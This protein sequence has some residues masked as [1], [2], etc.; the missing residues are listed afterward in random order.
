MTLETLVE[1]KKTIALPCAQWGDT[2]KG[3]FVDFFAEEWADIVIRGTGGAN[4]GHT[5]RFGDKEIV[6][7]LIPSGI[8]HDRT[9]TNIIGNGV[10]LDPWETLHEIQRLH[11]AGYSTD[12]LMISH[13][14]KL[15][16]PQHILLDRLEEAVAGKEKLGTT[17]RGIGKAYED[18]PAR[19]ALTVNDLLNPDILHKKL[20]RNLERRARVLQTY[21]PALVKAIL[22]DPEV[23]SFR[24]GSFFNAEAGLSLD[25]LMAFYTEYGVQLKEH[26]RDTQKYVREHVGRKK[27]LLEGAQGTLL[28]VDYGTIPFVTSS[29]CSIEGL[30]KGAGVNR[31]EVDLVLSIVKAPYMTR[32]GEGPFP[33]ELGGTESAKHC[34]ASRREQEQR[35]Y[36]G[37]SVNDADPLR[38]GIAIRR[39]GNEFG[40]TTSRPR[41]VGWLDLPLLRYAAQI[42]GPDIIVTKPDVLRGCNTINIC[43]AY[44]Y[45]GPNMYVGE[46][47]LK[48]GQVLFTAIPAAEVLQHCTPLYDQLPGWHEDLREARAYH[49]LPRNFRAIMNYI[50]GRAGVHIRIIS[51]GP[52]RTQTIIR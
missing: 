20:K 32:V 51:F 42:N 34:N 11:D 39:E 52:E 19:I 2:G 38:Q 44:R 8:L 9:V 50:E 22:S 40:A 36:H 15:V 18:V 37:V 33:T 43:D 21:D 13:N 12:N 28:S 31:S 14:A 23:S 3:K 10:V 25:A 47:E 5:I 24:N 41:R 16:L 7:H 1:G 49:E 6:L 26:V 17:G 48:K 27:I 45:D 35:E 30:A 4:A 46:T 29:D